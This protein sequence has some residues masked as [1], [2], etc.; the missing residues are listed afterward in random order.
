[1]E[2]MCFF[3][4]FSETICLFEYLKGKM[5]YLLA[6]RYPY[7]RIIS[8]WNVAVKIYWK[9]IEYKQCFI[10]VFKSKSFSFN[11]SFGSEQKKIVFIEVQR[12]YHFRFSFIC[13][14][15]LVFYMD[16]LKQTFF[17]TFSSRIQLYSNKQF[18]S[19][20][21]LVCWN[22]LWITEYLSS[23]ETYFIYAT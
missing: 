12:F 15:L 17:H 20:L 19:I 3:Q 5:F 6:V 13:C 22:K 23:E 18:L 9:T 2:K 4:W 16:S 21:V 7:N 8:K 14:F 11:L 1:M 10:Y